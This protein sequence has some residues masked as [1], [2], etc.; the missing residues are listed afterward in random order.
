MQQSISVAICGAQGYSG[1]ALTK[2]VLQH[3][4][5]QLAGVFSRRDTAK[6]YQSLPQLARHQT[7]IWPMNEFHDRLATIDVLLLATPAA[8]SMEL[9]AAAVRHVSHVIDLSG[10]FRLPPDTF[11]KWYGIAHSAPELL[12]QAVYGLIP[13]WQTHTPSSHKTSLIAN[14]GCYATCSLMALLP[15][16]K[17]NLLQTDRI[18]I[19]AKSG[20]SG[21]GRTAKESLLFCEVTD[22]FF[23]YKIGQHQHTP[24]I[25]HTLERYTGQSAQLTLTTHLLPIIRGISLTCYAQAQPEFTNDSAIEEAVEQAYCQAYRDYPLVSFSRLNQAQPQQHLLAVNQVAHTPETHIVYYVQQGQLIIAA[26][27]D[28][29]LKGAASQAIENINA[30]YGWS[31][32]TGLLTQG[33][34]A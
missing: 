30:L 27:L 3:P 25:R 1:Q 28:N 29:L 6:V 10:A 2:L 13:W 17:Q 20:A 21:A 4:H 18:I 9:A 22:N 33:E 23:P 31:L 12:D 14:P 16:L 19:D 15:L 7:S 11:A 5:L 24:E 32:T 8:T 34:Y 26:S